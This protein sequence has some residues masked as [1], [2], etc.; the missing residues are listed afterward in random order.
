MS[1]FLDQPLGHAF[2]DKLK[3]PN[4]EGGEIRI[5]D[6]VKWVTIIQIIFSKNAEHAHGICNTYKISKL[7]TRKGRFTEKGDAAKN[8]L[9][10]PKCSARITWPMLFG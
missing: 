2:E 3:F 9:L 1:R 10:L 6:Y 5:A 7:T 4:I 8:V